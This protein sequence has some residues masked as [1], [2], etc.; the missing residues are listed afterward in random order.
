MVWRPEKVLRKNLALN[1]RPT[2]AT[3]SWSATQVSLA[4]TS[5]GISLTPGGSSNDSFATVSVGGGPAP[6]SGFVAGK[7][8]TVTATGT[9]VGGSFATADLIS[10]RDRRMWYTATGGTAVAGASTVITSGSQRVSVTFTIPSGTTSFVFRFYNG[11]KNTADVFAWTDVLIEEG[12]SIGTYFDGS[13]AAANGV[14]YRWDG[15]VYA[16]TSSQYIPAV[17]TPT[18]ATDWSSANL[19]YNE[20]WYVDGIDIQS[21]AFGVEAVDSS[22]PSMR[23]GHTVVPMQSGVIPRLNRSY[24]P[25]TIAF[26]MWVLGCDSDGTIPRVSSE[27][28]QLF[29]RNQ[30]LLMRLFG[31][32]G[33]T[34]ELRRAYVGDYQGAPSSYVMAR[35]VIDGFNGFDTMAGRQRA[36]LTVAMT[37]IDAFWSDV[38]ATTDTSS[39]SATLPQTLRLSDPGTAPIEDAVITVTG[40]ITNPRVTCPSSG[41]WVQYNGAVPAGQTMVIDSAKGS[42]TVNGSSVLGSVVRGGSARLMLIPPRE[43]GTIGSNSFQTSLTLSGSGASSATNFS[44]KYYR[45][46][47]VIV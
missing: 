34:V 15:A 5:N 9:V 35:A 1:P 24:D 32:Q 19:N 13:T 10:G 4:A 8:Y 39:A 22:P 47:L 12:S 18:T 42:V 43:N 27:R 41:S 46:H 17:L 31:Y 21:A 37:L 29:E 6:M 38:N 7:T 16:A 2:S 45:K 36:Q 30:R 25:G 26:K 44:V 28:R 3:T 11:S 23:G 33:K 40:P 20:S 14:S